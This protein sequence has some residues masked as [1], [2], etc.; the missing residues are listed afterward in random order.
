[1]LT[2]DAVL[3]RTGLLFGDRTAF[4]ED[5]RTQSWREHIGRVGRIAG[6]LVRL[7]IGRGDKFAVFGKN[8]VRQAEI[9]HAAYWLGAVPVPTAP[10]HRRCLAT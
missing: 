8:S 10:G 4:I 7:G 3:H 1:M 2:L 6:F 5:H 9:F